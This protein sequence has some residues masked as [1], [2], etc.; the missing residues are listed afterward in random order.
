MLLRDRV[1]FIT[2]ASRGAGAALARA[3][4]REGAAVGVNYL[5][6]A[7]A[8]R[9]VVEG[10]EAEGGRALALRADVT[11]EAAVRQAVDTLAEHFGRLDGVVNN[12]LPAYA[13]DPAASYV[14]LETLDWADVAR[15]VEGA[16]RGTIHTVRAALPHFR[17][18]GYGKV[19]NVSSNLVYH[20][21]VTYHDYTAAKAALVGLTRTLAAEL[22]PEGVRV[23][24]VAGGLLETTDA[25]AMTT[26]E[27]FAYV[28]GATPLRKTVTP[29]EFAQAALFFLSPLSDAVTGQSLSVDG[30]LTMP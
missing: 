26:P 6:R 18:R 1:F 10:I 5:E 16:V 7:E 15:Q 2:G 12:A 9:G 30:G 19:L 13:F 14:R 27:V 3:V 21:V 4:A 11:D 8:A 24:L 17:A 29:D 28:A 22:G 25:S 20:P 23:N